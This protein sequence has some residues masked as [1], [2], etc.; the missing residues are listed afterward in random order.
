MNF[1]LFR[2]YTIRKMKTYC[3]IY[4]ITLKRRT[5]STNMTPVLTDSSDDQKVLIQ[6]VKNQEPEIPLIIVS[7]C[8]DDEADT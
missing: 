5:V 7:P 3:K 4:F 6:S 1:S 2:R 8:S